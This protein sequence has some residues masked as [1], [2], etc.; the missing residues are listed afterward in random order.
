MK[1]PTLAMNLL[2]LACRRLP[3]AVALGFLSVVTNAPA[4]RVAEIRDQNLT[5]K[6]YVVGTEGGA[7]V[8]LGD[9]VTALALK[10]IFQAQG[11]QIETKP[12]GNL[13]MVFSNGTGVFMDRDTRLDVRLFSQE[14]FTA[15]RTDLELEPSVSHTEGFIPQGILAVST[16]KLAAGSTI[17]F[18]T[19]FGSVNLHDGDLVIDSSSTATK[20]YLLRG[21]T[22]VSAGPLDLGRRVL[23]V[24]EQVI[25]S[26]G[27]PGRPNRL[28]LSR[29]PA[30]ALPA[31]EA[32]AARA[33]AARKT[34]FF[35][36]DEFGN[37]TGVP[38]VNAALPVEA[39]ISPSQLPN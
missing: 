18:I 3:A 28:E 16:S 32:L 38:V 35:Q 31:L 12:A 2:P 21:E 17:T 37:I 33:Y 27:P 19:P 8:A 39:A 5:G 24:G 30:S 26:A 23:E 14:P 22:T 29:I 25:I 9:K 10:A 34:V 7:Q 36:S 13:T 15:S 20:F 6:I 1:Y 4:A 11:S